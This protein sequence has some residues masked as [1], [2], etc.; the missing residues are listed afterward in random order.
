MDINDGS[1]LTGVAAALQSVRLRLLVSAR[2]YPMR[3]Y[4]GSKLRE[5]SSELWTPV[6]RSRLEGVVLR[7]CEGLLDVERLELVR[8]DGYVRIYVNSRYVMEVAV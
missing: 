5:L 1:V 4:A 3:P 8:G 7:A 2:Y 6:T